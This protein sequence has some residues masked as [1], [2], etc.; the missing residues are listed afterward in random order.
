[1]R[2][3]AA[4]KAQG[5]PFLLIMRLI[6]MGKMTPPTDEPVAM[7]PMAAP[8]FLSNQVAIVVSASLRRIQSA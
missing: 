4:L 1:M 3:A 6:I 2:N 8:R 5:Y 7:I